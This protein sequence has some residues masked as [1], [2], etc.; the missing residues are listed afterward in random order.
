MLCRSVC[1]VVQILETLVPWNSHASE[2]H[3]GQLCTCKEHLVMHQCQEVIT[4]TFLNEVLVADS[5]CPDNDSRLALRLG[6]RDTSLLMRGEL[7][8]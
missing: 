4:Q 5:S 6:T 8:A 1:D 2:K 7:E 3:W